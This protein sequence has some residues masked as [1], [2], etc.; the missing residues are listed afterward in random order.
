LLQVT[1]IKRSEAASTVSKVEQT[2]TTT[3]L[4]TTTADKI[5]EKIFR[6]LLNFDKVSLLNTPKIYSVF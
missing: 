4:V 2:T 1:R 3:Q 6:E 5:D